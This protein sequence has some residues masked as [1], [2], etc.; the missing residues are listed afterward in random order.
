[1]SDKVAAISKILLLISERELRNSVLAIL[2]KTTILRI[3]LFE[4]P[5]AFFEGMAKLLLP[6]EFIPYFFEHVS[7]E[8]SFWE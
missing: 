6:F 1:M 5:N 8:C 2:P 4:C 3:S 7:A